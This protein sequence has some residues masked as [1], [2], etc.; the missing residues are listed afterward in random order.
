MIRRTHGLGVVVSAWVFLAGAGCA[1][2]PGPPAGQPVAAP[3]AAPAAVE[4]IQAVIDAARREGQL[5]LVWSGIDDPEAIRR[6]AEGFNRTYGLTLNIQFTPG[7]AMPEMA[8][9]IAQEYQAGRPASTDVFI[10]TEAHIPSLMQVD[11]LEPVDW[12]A[13]APNLRNPELLAPNGVAVEVAT[14]TPGITYHTGKLTGDAVP[15]TAEDLLKPLYKGRLASTTYAANFDRLASPELWGERRTVEYVTRLAE[16]VA[17]LIRC[18]ETE[19]LVSGEFDLLGLDCGGYDARRGQA[20]GAPLGH[21]IPAD[22]P[23][24]NYWYVAVPRHAPHPNAAKLWVNYLLGREAQDI[25]YSVHFVD[26][27]LV[28]GSKTAEEVEKLQA[29][30]VRF[31]EVDVDWVLRHDERENARLRNEFQRILRKQ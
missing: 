15:R 13:W 28:P 29:Q 22:A 9:R 10:G 5:T 4:P 8:G 6:L 14:R 12:P 17:G 25:I 21:V 24:L 31:T 18:G 16:Q 30:G 7:P 27:H 3:P 19:R 1:P 26:H 20:Q 23:L 2:A 11:A